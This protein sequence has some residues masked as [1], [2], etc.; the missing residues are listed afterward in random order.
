[1]EFRALFVTFFWGK[2]QNPDE[3]D[4]ERDMFLPGIAVAQRAVQH[5]TFE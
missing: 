5:A 1:L 2:L 4:A 3:V